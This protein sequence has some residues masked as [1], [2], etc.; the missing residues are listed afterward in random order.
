MAAGIP[1]GVYVYSMAKNASE[2]KK[3]A[4]YTIKMMKA[5]GATPSKTK[6]PVYIDMEDKTQLAVGKAKLADIATTFCNYVKGQG[7]TPGVY[8]NRSWFKNYLTDPCF[9]KWTRWIAQYPSQGKLDA[10]C[11]DS[12]GQPYMGS[13][14]MWQCMSSGQ[15]NG[16]K[17][18]VDMNFWYGS[19]KKAKTVVAEPFVLTR[20][21]SP[22]SIKIRS[23]FDFVGV[24]SSNSKLARVTASIV[25]SN[26]KVVQSKAATPNATTFSLYNSAID[27]GLE[28]D[29][30]KV[31]TYYYQVTAKDANDTKRVLREAFTV[32][33]YTTHFTKV[34]PKK[35]S[36]ALKWEKR[37]YQVTSYQ[38]RW[39]TNKSMKNAKTKTYKKAK[40][41]AKSI[42]NLKSKKT[43]YVQIRT[44]KKVDGKK[45]YGQWSSKVKVKTK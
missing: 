34:T 18:R 28:V 24:L 3:E 4:A 31:G 23:S 42:K 25:D 8:A 5:V 33:P 44:Y 14:G 22:G 35:N 32:Y 15:V 6:Y 40:T 27:N 37:T 39:S 30:L 45:I 12:N 38:I 41:T 11:S 36:V 29:K 43:Y 7:Y 26:G 20:Y 19:T 17:G 13:Y 9:E 2:A 21:S 10:V 16:I 1:F